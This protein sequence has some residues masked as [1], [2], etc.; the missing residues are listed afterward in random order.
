VSN[1]SFVHLHVHTEYSMLDGASR[2]DNLFEKA[3]EL[4][5]PAVAMT[6]HGNLFGAFEFWK[7]GSATNVKP[8]IGIEG[9]YAPQGRKERSPFDFGSATLDDTSS[10]S[11]GR[12]RYNYTHMTLWSENNV[13]LHNLFRLSSLASLEGYY[14]QPRFDAELLAT[15]GKGLIGT[16]G[17]PSGEVNRWLQA[18]NYKKAIETAGTMRDILGAGNY[19]VE[20]MDHG[21]GIE[22]QTRADLIK[23]SKEL[24][25]PLVATNDSHYVYPEDAL[26]HEVL[27]CIGTRTTMDDP[28]RFKFDSQ[29]FYLKSAA[30]MRE[31]WRELP[32]ACDNTLLIAERCNVDFTEGQD[33]LPNFPVPAG[34]TQDTWLGKE[35]M[36]GLA[37][38]FGN[39]T[40]PAEHIER[41]KFELQVVEQMGFPGYF[42]VVADLCRHAREEGIR[43]GPGRGSAAGAVIAW[44]LGITELD[45]I[46]HGLLFERFL[47]P[48]RISMPDIDIDFDERRRSEMIRY[49]TRKYGEERVAQIVT[50]GTIKAKAAVK[51]ATRALG[52]P[53]ALGD[54]V[55]KVMPPAIMG[56]DLSLAGVFDPENSRYN[57]AS[58]IRELYEDDADI[59]KIV[60][61]ARGIEGLKRQ[62][63]VHAAG[64]ILCREPLIDVIPVW[65]REQDGAVITQFDM[66]ACE[67]LGLLKMDFLGL[68][69]LTVLDDTLD[70]IKVNRGETVVLEDLPLAD[71]KTF[72]LLS[73]GDTLGVFQLDGGPMRSLLR[74]LVPDSF[75]DISAVIALYR[76]GPMGA[77][78]HNDY[79]D[80]KNKRKVQVPLHLELTEALDSILGDTYGLIVYQEQVMAIAQKLAGYTLGQAD[81]LR[82]AMGKK[83]AEILEKEYKPFAQGMKE[84]GYSDDSISTL[85]DKLVPFSDYAFNRA[86]SAGYGLVSFWTAYLKANYPAE[87]MAALLSS[88]KD[89]KDKSAVYLNECRRMGI[90]VLP[91]DVN[92]SD[93][94]FAAIGE[95]IRFGLSAIRNVGVN[96]VESLKA[97]RI[98]KGK[99]VSFSD[100]LAKVDIQVCNKRVVESLIKAGAFDSLGHTRKGLTAI[101]L[102]AVDAVLDTKKQEAIGQFDLFGSGGSDNSP[103]MG[104]IEINIGLDEWDKKFLLAQERDMLGLYVSDHPL[105]GLEHVLAINTSMPISGVREANDGSIA[106]L[107]GL[108]TEIQMKTTKRSGERWAIVALEDLEGVTEILVWPK[109]F[110]QIGHLL[111]EDAIV[112]IK[113]RIDKRDDEAPRVAALEINMPDIAG[114]QSGPVKLFIPES[115]INPSVMDSLKNILISHQGTTEVHLTLIRDESLIS[116]KTDDK[117]R[118]NPTP[119]LFADL[120]ALLGPGCLEAPTKV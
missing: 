13:G 63:G 15:Y 48:E 82:R 73:R 88:V 16:T 92:E 78:A 60:D 55:T 81:L 91:P 112:L 39:G 111:I 64:V 68:R 45:P 26:M 53:Y 56:K 9:Y 10:D 40:I 25:L 116:L 46:K 35:V 12:G 115:R 67:A 96:V 57:E 108:I 89:D 59:R 49:A 87:Y 80:Y 79:A 20:L 76:P 83:K 85:W 95:D 94:D 93:V 38:R 29:D 30:E 98:A 61:T 28:K 105:F 106:T 21:I 44:A 18:G 33:L 72:E 43:V 8:I 65:R 90:K 118:V 14:Y 32:E 84:R 3:G 110:N 86:H 58:E 66:G 74:S 69:N 51:D 103:S 119:S 97:T 36:L 6:D 24:N 7:K 62:P 27:L 42:L 47:N 37:K 41:A 109:M 5:Q 70:N 102:E 113:V 71:T 52:F 34:E 31:L 22:R 50:Y 2:L 54:K 77:N 23:I 11:A 107:G 104:G 120:K 101:H 1:D 19:F 75:E 4:G 100:F 17:C 117:L 99:Y 114:A